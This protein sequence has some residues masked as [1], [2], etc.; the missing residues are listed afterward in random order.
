MLCAYVSCRNS[1]FAWAFVYFLP[2]MCMNEV[3]AHM[4][5]H[6]VMPFELTHICA[7]TLSCPSS[8]SNLAL[9]CLLLGFWFS[10]ASVV[11]AHIDAIMPAHF[12]AHIGTITPARICTHR[13]DH[14]CRY[15]HTQARSCLHVSHSCLR[16]YAHTGS[17]MPSPICTYRRNCSCTYMHTQAQSCLRVYAHIGAIMPTR[18]RTHRRDRAC[19]SHI[20]AIMPALVEEIRWACVGL[21]LPFL[22]LSFVHCLTQPRR[23]GFSSLVCA[24]AWL[25]QGLACLFHE[26]LNQFS[27][28]MHAVHVLLSLCTK[29]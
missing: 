25:F 24:A 27:Q 22:L 12:Y 11:Y 1:L 15:M 29:E 6:T 3:Y 23:L 9:S 26:R 28:N 19:A 21:L 2:C 16:L 5:I 8:W 14:A 20:G 18:K 17:I 7:Y 10:Q 13:Q 4:R